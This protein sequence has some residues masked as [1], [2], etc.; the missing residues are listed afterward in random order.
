MISILNCDYAVESRGQTLWSSLKLCRRINTQTACTINHRFMSL[1]SGEN[2]FSAFLSVREIFLQHQSFRHN[3][4]QS[5]EKGSLGT[6]FLEKIK[7][8]K[9]YYTLSSWQAPLEMM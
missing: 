1:S 3:L 8:P 2:P 4:T 9:F 7:I 6:A 5:S